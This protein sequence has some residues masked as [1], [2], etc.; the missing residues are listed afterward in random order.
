MCCFRGLLAPSHAQESKDLQPLLEGTGLAIPTQFLQPVA[1]DTSV[2]F[3]GTSLSFDGYGTPY[4]LD[5]A[6]TFAQGPSGF[7][8]ISNFR[9][10]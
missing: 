9:T 8:F 5:D 6:A 1:S 7:G 4:T 3:S 10:R 2:T